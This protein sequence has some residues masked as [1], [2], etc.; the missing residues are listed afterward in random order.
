MDFTTKKYKT[1]KK[2][3]E[4]AREI[5]VYD[6]VDVVVAGAGLAGCCAALKAARDGANVILIERDGILGGVATAGLMT[7]ITN[8][9]FKKD[10]TQVVHDIVE[11]IVDSLT[12]AGA[13]SDK[14]KNVEVP[15]IPNNSEVMQECLFKKLTEAGV[16]ILIHTF[17]SDVIMEGD[18]A[19]GV[20]IETKMGR[21]AIMAKVLVDSTGDAD[22]AYHAGAEYEYYGH[23]S[24]STLFELANVDLD[25]IMKFFEEHP[26]NFDEQKDVAL[27]FETFR[28]NYYERGIFHTPHGGGKKLSI[29][30]DAIKEGKWWHEKGTATKLDHFG[31]YA[32]RGSNRL[33]VN[34]HFCYVDTLSDVEA[35][36]YAELESRLFCIQ[37]AKLMTERMPGCEN[38]Y[39]SR[40]STTMGVRLTRNIIGDIYLTLDDVKVNRKYNNVIFRTPI[41]YKKREDGKDLGLRLYNE[42]IGI[43]V[44][45]LIP[46]NVDNI[47][48]GT[49]KC[50]S[51]DRQSRQEFL[52]GQMNTMLFG[53]AAG[54]IA[55]EAVRQNKSIKIM[56]VTTITSS[57]FA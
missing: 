15:C 2:C 35:H 24:C 31:L 11:E 8:F 41:L 21:M 9:F 12:E 25:K 18:T 32:T 38:A 57:N 17:V 47:V 16:R 7:C 56:D 1:N 48:I 37:L 49:G 34:S 4:A 19:R 30:Q 36:S 27:P 6:E 14:W 26:E 5:P 20:I 53:V 45:V 33:L 52:R 44:E 43:P 54:K 39:L 42:T 3:M 22:L 50:I 40:I 23:D 28:K 10:G 51:A 55:A 46:K 13:A 29:L